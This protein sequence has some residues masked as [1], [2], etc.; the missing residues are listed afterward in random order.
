MYT[1]HD[2]QKIL[3]CCFFIDRENKHFYPEMLN[4]K[5]TFQNKC[6]RINQKQ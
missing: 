6:L 4:K 2:S 1:N 3:R 5:F